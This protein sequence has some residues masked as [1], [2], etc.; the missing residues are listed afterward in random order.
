M[1][2]YNT[3]QKKVVDFKPI[4]NNEVRVYSCGPTVYDNIHIGNLNAFIAADTLRRTIQLDYS[5]KHVMNLTDIDDKTIKNSAEAY[6]DM[7]PK[8][9]LTKL[10]THFT[11]AFLRDMALIGNGVKQIKFIKATDSIEGMRS[12]IRE[13]YQDGF[14]YLADDGVY[15]S[16]DK[17]RQSGKT[18]GQLLEITDENTSNSRISN[19]EYSKDSVNDFALWKIGKKGEPT[20]PFEISEKVIDGRPGWHIECSVMSCQ[21]LGQPFDIHTGGVDLVFPHHENEIAQSTAGK[22][23]VYASNFVH[24]EHLLV[25]GK[26]MSKSLKNFYTLEDITDKGFDPLSFRLLSLQS[27]YR[28]RTNFSWDNLESAQNSLKNIYSWSDLSF[29]NLE[30]A[31]YKEAATNTI[32]SIKDHMRND[33]N[34]P[35]ALAELFKLIKQVE[36]L[37]ADSRAIAD[38]SQLIED[39]FALGTVIRL[40][41]SAEQSKLLNSR[42]TARRSSDWAL[43]DSIKAELGIQFIEVKDTKQGQT[44]SRS[45]S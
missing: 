32:K 39:L 41:I 25:D 24:N 2:I 34:S 12:L 27:H 9:A 21:S 28:S 36:P 42:E 6:S 30:S 44:W 29:Q 11:D 8:L 20:W 40:T 4:H 33:M 18:Y 1:K 13:L 14:A 22:G 26:K 43:A 37:G 7:D 23:D 15:F 3:L 38:V 16:I 5:I 10:T 31:E 45:S 35:E 19:D 17:Y